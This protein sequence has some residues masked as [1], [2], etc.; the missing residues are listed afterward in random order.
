MIAISKQPRQTVTA[1]HNERFLEMLPLIRHRAHLAFR[2]LRP[3]LKAE[4]VA[5]TIATAFCHFSRLVRAG[6]TDSAYATPLAD[7]SI[8]RVLDGRQAATKFN[9]RDL[10]SHRRRAVAGGIVECLNSFDP[11]DGEWREALVEDHRATPADI[12]AA[13]IDV[14]EWFR[15]MAPRNRRIAKTLAMGASTSEAA[16]RFRVSLARISQLRRELRASWKEFQG[17][18]A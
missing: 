14:A 9:T 3:E 8:R 10:M 16:G 17:E 6:K 7:F 12:A 1:Q 15:L 11:E 5:E 2:R 4:L 18:I 13:R